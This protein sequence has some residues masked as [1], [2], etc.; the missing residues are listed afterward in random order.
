M[1]VD[2]ISSV[3]IPLK[4][5]SQPS[6]SDFQSRQEVSV[7]LEGALKKAITFPA[8][9]SNPASRQN[10]LLSNNSANSYV[11]EQDVAGTNIQGRDGKQTVDDR[12]MDHVTESLR[13]LYVEAT[14]F[15]VAWSIAK[16]TG[17]D[18]ETLLKAQ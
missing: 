1:S 17:R 7:V 9:D 2:P 15:A 11:R 10:S 5:I 16:R 12:A 18:V 14:N 6:N 3:S 13:G 8:S 4:S